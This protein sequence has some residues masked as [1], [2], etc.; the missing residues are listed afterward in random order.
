MLG[1][2]WISWC[3]SQITASGRARRGSADDERDKRWQGANLKSKDDSGVKKRMMMGVVH[4]SLHASAIKH[5]VMFKHDWSW[6]DYRYCVP[7]RHIN[8]L[9]LAMNLAAFAL[10]F[11]LS[12]GVAVS[13]LC[14]SECT[15]LQWVHCSSLLTSCALQEWEQLAASVGLKLLPAP[16]GGSLVWGIPPATMVVMEPIWMKLNLP[17]KKMKFS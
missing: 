5:Q 13:V 10:R 3:R 17:M 2:G 15:V 8:S 1:H 12:R 7:E 6:D 4:V 16:E 14:C 11:L 9:D